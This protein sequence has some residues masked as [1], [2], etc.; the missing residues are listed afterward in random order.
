MN[1]CVSYD[2]LLNYK[3]SEAPPTSPQ[4]I[5]NFQ[6]VLIQTNDILHIKLSG[7]DPIALQPFTSDQ[8][9][10]SGGINN[11]QNLLLDGYLVDSKGTVDLP[12]LGSVELAGL[13]LEAAKEKLKTLL[14]A[15]FE[16]LPIVNV[17]LLNFRINING[18]VK[19]PGVLTIDNQSINLVEA[20]TMAGDLTDYSQ[21]DSILIIREENGQRNFAYIDLNSASAFTSP[22]FYLQQNDVVYVRPLKRKRAIVRDP[23]TNIFTWISAITGIA[24]FILTLTRL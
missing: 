23:A 14:S 5:A 3:T 12:T 1:G 17:R 22:Y 4:A 6:P 15:Y 9:N 19:R 11:P 13:S 2:S 20:L 8:S 24:A 21:R 7:V 18:E 16:E 10:G